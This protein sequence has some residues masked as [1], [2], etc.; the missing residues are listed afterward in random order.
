MDKKLL[1][2]QNPF[3]L[4]HYKTLRKTVGWLGILLPVILAVG[5]VVIF[6]CDHVETSISNY[7]HTNMG[8]VFVGVLCAFSVFLFTYKGPQK[9]DGIMGNIAG[10]FGTIAAICPTTLK[11]D[12][13]LPGGMIPA[14]HEKYVGIIHLS[15]A[16]LFFL[17]LAYFSLFLFTKTSGIITA[18][19]IRR[20]KVYKICGWVMI[21]CILLLIPYFAMPSYKPQFNA[22]KY[23]FCLETLA[24]WAFGFSWLTKGEFLLKDK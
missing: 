10:T 21:A 11:D 24:L 19:K 22:Y 1:R 14:A 20:N 17:V 7:Y 16:A 12:I 8:N 4:I 18:Q 13:C 2:Q 15:S 5:S 6:G 3:Y 9:I 23:V